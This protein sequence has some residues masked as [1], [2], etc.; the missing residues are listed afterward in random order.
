MSLRIDAT[1]WISGALLIGET[2][3]GVLGADIPAYGDAGAGYAYNDLT[4]PED[5]NKEICGRITSWPSAGTLVANEDTSFV[6]SDAPDGTYSFEYQLYVDGVATGTSTSVTLQVGPP[7]S[8]NLITDSA[9]MSASAVVTPIASGA[10]VVNDAVFSGISSGGASASA[11]LTTDGSA[12]VASASVNPLASASLITA[13]AILSGA[14]GAGNVAFGAISADNA[15]IVSSG[16]V[17]PI[18][19]TALTTDALVVVSAVNVSPIVSAS[20][21][22]S[23]SIFTGSAGAG[24]GIF[25]TITT[26]SSWASAIAKVSPVA[27]MPIYTAASVFSG[28]ASASADAT[29]Y[30]EQ[31]LSEIVDDQVIVLLQDEVIQS[32]IL[33]GTT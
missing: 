4:F 20:L 30:I 32:N 17:K 23:S 13:S 18:T 22:T 21:V 10:V 1:E 29:L 14:S 15:V 26:E 33:S 7:V 25:A 8:M 6:F 2:G 16:T 27:M 3:L 5:A 24:A 9:V 31:V 19:T 11:T 12:I 28:S